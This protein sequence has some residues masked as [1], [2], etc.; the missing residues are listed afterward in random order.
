MVWSIGSN[1]HVRC[2]LLCRSELT[3]ENPKS[4]AFPQRTGVIFD[5]HREQARSYKV[6]PGSGKPTAL[7]RLEEGVGRMVE[8]L[9]RGGDHAHRAYD[10][11]V[12]QAQEIQLVPRCRAAEQFR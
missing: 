6:A 9:S 10:A 1:K 12:F 8:G 5:V 7:E 2:L 11:L 4:A 3:R